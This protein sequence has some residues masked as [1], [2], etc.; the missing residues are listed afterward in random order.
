MSRE[1]QMINTIA[2]KDLRRIIGQSV[3]P[4]VTGPVL[5]RSDI[6]EGPVALTPTR[7]YY[8]DGR[9]L[10]YEITDAEA[11]WTLLRQAKAEHSEHGATVLLPAVELFRNRRLFV[12]HDGM[13]VFALG[14]TEDTRGYLSSV[15]KSPN[16]PGSM[17]QLLQLAIQ[18][19]ANHLYCFD[20][21]LTAYYRRLGFRPVCRVSFEMFGEPC[22]WNRETFR[23]YGPAGKAGCPDV[24]Y[25]CYEP[26]QP[27]SCAADPVDVA[28]VSTDIPYASSL[29]Q[30]KD[31]LKGEVDRVSALH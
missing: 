9:L 17:T 25:F 1:I 8:C 30:A 14:N 24:N 28:L 29:Q 26:C 13:A 21:C 10:A 20:T 18:E 19:G 6:P 22:D 7:H 4:T 2:S 5:V 3:D 27:L 31:I 12:S 16:Y 23:A 11:F 15:C